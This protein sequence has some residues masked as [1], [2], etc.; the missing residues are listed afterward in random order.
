MEAGADP[1]RILGLN[2]QSIQNLSCCDT[3]EEVC[4]WI[5]GGVMDEFIDAVRET[6]DSPPGKY[7]RPYYSCGKTSRPNLPWQT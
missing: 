3:F 5:V 7:E 4:F 6:P 2:Y 1:E